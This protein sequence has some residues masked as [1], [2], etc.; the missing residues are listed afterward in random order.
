MFQGNVKRRI[1]EIC[2]QRCNK[3][4]DMGQQSR[5]RLDTRRF[6]DVSH[7]ED[8]KKVTQEDGTIDVEATP[9]IEAD[10]RFSNLCN[11]ACLD[12]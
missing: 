1:L 8:S 6:F 10:I 9:I 12:M 2:L 11:L 3:E 4:D 5:R 7:Y